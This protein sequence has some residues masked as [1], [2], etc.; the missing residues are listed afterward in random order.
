MEPIR[1]LIVREDV[2]LVDGVARTLAGNPRIAGAESVAADEPW[3]DSQ[4]CP[5]LI[6]VDARPGSP[7]S[8]VFHRNAELC[9][10]ARVLLLCRRGDDAP[11]DLGGDVHASGYIQQDDAGEIVPI[12]AALVALSGGE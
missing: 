9:P 12:V 10:A 8:A 11:L 6:V 7:S 3:L 2:D 5:D 4:G 1:V